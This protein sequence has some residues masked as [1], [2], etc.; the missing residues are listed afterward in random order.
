MDLFDARH[1]DVLDPAQL[2]ALV[3]LWLRSRANRG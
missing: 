3:S 2:P 1:A